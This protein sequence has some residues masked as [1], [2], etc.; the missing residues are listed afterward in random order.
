MKVEVKIVSEEVMGLPVVNEHAAGIDVGSTEMWVT[1]TN[2]EGQTCQ[3]M[4]GCCTEELEYLVEHLWMEGVTDVAIESTGIYGDNV[5]SM[6]ADKGIEV[7]VINPSLYKKP[8]IKTDG[9]DSI[10]LHQYHTVDLFRLSHIAPDYWREVREY[11]QERESIAENKGKILVK[12]QRQLDLMNIK[13]PHFVSDVE[14]VSSMRVLRAIASGITDPEELLSLMDIHRFKADRETL[15]KSLKGNYRHGLVN[16]LKEKIKEYD[17][18]LSQMKQYDKYLAESLEKIKMILEAQEKAMKSKEEEEKEKAVE[19]TATE[20]KEKKRSAV[21]KKSAQEPSR[22][23]RKNELTFNAAPTLKEILGIDLTKVEGLEV[24][25]ILVL[26]SVTGT[27]MSKWR[28]S[29]AFASWLCLAPRPNISNSKLKG[30]DRRKTTNPAT[31]ALRLAARSLHNSDSRLGQLYRKVNNKK[32]AK[33][34]IKCVAR[35]L[36]VLIYTLIKNQEEYD[37]SY[38][39]EDMERQREKNEKKL[40][41][42]AKMY[43]YEIVKV[44]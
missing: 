33:A 43:G 25:T 3:F 17:F 23:S 5:R 4:T 8:E 44:A 29:G 41:K 22:K 2:L 6:L 42:L 31:Q 7:I 1:Y 27:D 11:M 24:K 14:G 32:G 35:H 20:S 37:D 12:I 13:L 40:H 28:N 16:I 30:Y 21:K 18:C 19:Q 10:W 34:A 26:L 39:I 38:Y 9:K 36:A 15:L